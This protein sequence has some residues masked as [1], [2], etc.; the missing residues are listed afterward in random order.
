MRSNICKIEKGTRD[1][2]AILKESE[3]VAEYNGLSHKQSLWL[4][5]LCEEIDGMLPNIIDDFD[6]ELWIDFEDGVGKVN[7]SIQIPEFN[8]DK[9]ERLIDIAKDK[10]NSASVGIVGKIRDAIENFFL[11]DVRMDAWAS[12]YGSFGFGTGYSEGV[13]YT[14]L[15]RLEEYRNFVAAEKG[16]QVSAW[17]E[18]E[19]SVIAS[20]ADDVIVGV[21]GREANITIVKKFA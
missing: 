10:K 17:D 20:V 18:L 7:V 8:I 11:S 1:L 2:E 16:K 4:R 9:K 6:G 21:K 12:S 19:K 15:W 14:Y 5:L 13:D 3:R